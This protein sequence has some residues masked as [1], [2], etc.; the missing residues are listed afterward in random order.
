MDTQNKDD[1]TITLHPLAIFGEDVSKDKITIRLT[2]NKKTKVNIKLNKIT[3]NGMDDKYDIL[4]AELNN[5][6]NNNSGN[7]FPNGTLVAVRIREEIGDKIVIGEISKLLI[8]EN[9]LSYEVIIDTLYNS[10]KVP[11]YD[12]ASLAHA[13]VLW[14]ITNL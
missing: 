8:I 10:V 5:K 13:D 6:V 9:K 11:A 1:Y 2:S 12:V 7:V 14:T 3:I 4:L